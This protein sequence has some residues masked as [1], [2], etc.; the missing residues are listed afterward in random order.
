MKCIISKSTNFEKIFKLSNFPIFMG[1]TKKYQKKIERKNLTF[2]IN[3]TT[4]T[5]Q[6]HPKVK[7]EKLYKHSHGSGVVGKTWANHH[8]FFFNFIKKN[9]NGKILEVGAG[10]NSIISKF[11]SFDKV[12]KF[13]SI[14]K[15][16]DENYKNNKIKI[17]DNFFSKKIIKKKLNTKIDTVIH[18]HFFEHVYSP[19]KFLKEVYSILSEGGY[20]C[21]SVPNMT[22]MLKLKQAN[23]VNFEHPYYYDREMIK[24]LLQSN[25]FKIIKIKKF[26]KNHSIMYITKKTNSFK[27]KKYSKYLKNKKIFTNLHSTWNKDKE[28]IENYL[29]NK[30]DIFLFGAH[31]FSQVI[32]HL[33]NKKQNIKGVLDNDKN[34]I[35]KY[36]NGSNLKVY[37]PSILKKHDEPY[38]YMRVGAYAKEIKKQV[39]LINKKTKFI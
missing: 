20:Q 21:F 1:V 11:K 4:G 39:L 22:E 18:S 9:L 12:D 27:K 29:S 23:A 14:G 34:K 31:I 32:L 17:I 35:N 26:L 3:K 5:V 24:Y 33:L 28:K 6:I 16:V 37:K 8:Q 13:Y 15:N 19:N 36:L 25:G 38:V 30:K 7:L 10:N 2:W